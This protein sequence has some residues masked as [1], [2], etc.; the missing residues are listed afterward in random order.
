MSKMFEISEVPIAINK[1]RAGLPEGPA[2]AFWTTMRYARDP[3]SLYEQLARYGDGHTV[4]MP[5]LLG[6]IV[7]AISPQSAKDILTADTSVLGVF[8]P[9]SVAMVFRPRS[10]VMLSGPPHARERKLLMPAFNRANAVR[11]YAVT[12]Q[13]TALAYTGE[14]PE[15]APFVMQKLAQRILLQIVVRDVFG[16]TEPDEQVELKQRT[17]DLFE[18]SSGALI[19]FPA[20]RH[21]FGGIGPYASWQRAGARLTELIHALIARRRAVPPGNRTD[22]LTMLLSARYDDGTAPS[23]EVLHDELMALFLAGH[24]ATAT[25][26]AWVFYWLHRHPETLAK[27][28]RELA[29]LPDDA[30]PAEYTKLAYL[31]AVCH[32]TLRIYPPVTDLYRQVRVPMKIGGHTIPAGTG[33][34]VLTQMIHARE[35]LFPEPARFRPER[36]AER[37]YTPFEFIPYGT[38]P[39]RC[40]GAAFAH[41]ALQ[42]VVATILRRYELALEAPNE[43]AVRQGVGLG[44]QRGVRMRIVRRADTRSPAARLGR[45]AP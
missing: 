19:F 20:L 6:P 25:S 14:L 34:A 4:T 22:V 15:G 7:A 16:V 21:R 8:D 43:R 24:A 10:V 44:P 23:D 3:V 11:S 12:M 9:A 37:S 39:R 42:V 41:Q 28:R 17:R 38:G 18:A 31:D 13:E 1:S 35:D 27:L 40:V 30:A 45:V 26:I 29:E 32:E 36:F 2:S 33:V 5:L